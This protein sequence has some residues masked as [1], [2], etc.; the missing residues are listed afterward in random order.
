M[1]AMVAQAV[2]TKDENWNLP[3]G[4]PLSKYLFTGTERLWTS[5]EPSGSWV[6]SR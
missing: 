1:R 2:P 4:K 3:W 6:S 5:Q